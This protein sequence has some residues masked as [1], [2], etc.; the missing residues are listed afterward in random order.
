[1]TNE[2]TITHNDIYSDLLNAL[3]RQK[4]TEE[5]ITRF[6]DSYLT[7]YSNA[8]EFDRQKLIDQLKA[9]LILYADF[10][11]PDVFED[12]SLKPEP[13]L[14]ENRDSIRWLYWGRYAEYL[15]RDNFNPHALDDLDS[16]TDLI[17]GGLQNPLHEGN[18]DSRGMVVGYIQ[19]GK[20]ANY[21]GL[22]C[23]AADAG[24][25]LII[26]LAGVHNDLRDQ[27][28]QRIDSGFIGTR[29]AEELKEPVGVGLISLEDKAF[30]REIPLE[31]NCLTS[32]TIN[33]DF[34]KPNSQ[35]RL[36]ISP[37]GSPYC[38]VV[39]KNVSVLKNLNE[40]IDDLAVGSRVPGKV[41]DIPLL[42][43]DDEADHASLNTRKY[44]KSE[45]QG[46]NDI[47]ST[48]RN[49]RAILNKFQKSAYVGY[50]ATPY[51]NVFIDP[52][53]NSENYGHDIFPRNFIISM[54]EP[55]GYFGSNIVFGKGPLGDETGFYPGIVLV[56]DDHIL[57]PPNKR[58]DSSFV[59]KEISPSLR[60]AILSFILSTAVRTVRNEG[61]NKV[62][63]NSMLIHVSR[64]VA[65]QGVN[66][67]SEEMQ[68]GLSELVNKELRDLRAALVFPDSDVYAE[69]KELWDTSFYPK[70]EEIR[71]ITRDTLCYA[72]SWERVK[73]I[74]KNIIRS[75]EVRV[76][77]GANKK[78]KLDYENYKKTG[79]NIIAIGGDK[80][81]RGLT[82]EGLTTSYFLRSAGA[83]DSLLQMGRWFGFRVGYVDV[84]R[85]YTT[86]D[87]IYK[88]QLVNVA[89]EHLRKQFRDMNEQEKTPANYG[90]K[91]IQND[92]RF[93]ITAQSKMRNSTK[94]IGNPYSGSLKQTYKFEVSP[95]I[96]KDN[97]QHLE[98]FISQLE[99]EIPHSRINDKDYIWRD[100][101][102]NLLLDCMPKI[103]VH[104]ELGMGDSLYQYIREQSSA[105]E[106]PE[107]THWN[108]V[109]V[110][111]SSSQAIRGKIAGLDVGYTIRNPESLEELERTGEY[112]YSKH[113]ILNAPS[114][115]A[116]DLPGDWKHIKGSEIRTHRPVTHGLLL[117]YPITW[118]KRSPKNATPLIGLAYSFP[119]SITASSDEFRG[120]S[121]YSKYLG[122]EE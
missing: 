74:L 60:E 37:R 26:V 49:I 41:L 11:K 76:L 55:P 92:P 12:K 58:R 81:S 86:D 87:L 91:I 84:C 5:T 80:L 114:D 23:K 38:L 40:W 75:I 69:F 7:L 106:M 31:V 52:D 17:L 68:T 27:T 34:K 33:G 51:A 39:K 83:Y 113:T 10:Q 79:L 4:P 94:H 20:T 65:T 118:T 117:V 82:L 119:L 59:P 89:D 54:P 64:Y 30:R 66:S 19:S 108:V 21:T 71:E 115:E 122:L 98:R 29:K 103:T 107:L 85:I 14:E 18:W 45:E 120:N 73:P 109:L 110:N 62:I 50:T 95:E 47:T 96:I 57:I 93:R 111:N 97:F 53:A 22:I 25:K 43:I 2:T 15:K 112:T 35:N 3:K 121:T 32:S 48:N 104:P 46:E 102:A 56:D 77:S 70:S 36:N 8:G 13:W 42:L 78:D 61:V 1:M 99:K 88:F 63:H 44:E 105:E 24:Y 100:V 9:D 101:P 16:T 90:L 28:Q 72:V 6:V 67:D 116:L